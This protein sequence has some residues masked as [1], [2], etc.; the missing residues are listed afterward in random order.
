VVGDAAG[1]HEPQR[2]VDLGGDRLV[3]LPRRRGAHELAVPVV[4][5]VQ[6]GH[7]AAGQGAHQ[8]HRRAGVGVRA[9]HAARV[10]DAELRVAGQGVD[11]VSAVGPETEGVDVRRAGL[12]VLPGDAADLDHRRRRAVGEHDGHLQQRADVAAQVGLGVVGEGLRAVTALQQE[13]LAA[14]D[15]RE[16]VLQPVHL[17]GH[18]D[19]RDVLEHLADVGHRLGVRPRGLLQRGTRQRH[20]EAL[21]QGRGQR[22]QP[23]ERIHGQV[24]GPHGASAY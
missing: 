20:V 18:G 22:G 11:H 2:A 21:T 4:H 23:G 1:V 5:L 8:V 24:D 14:R 6:V 15:R 19:R 17:G 12:R 10:G 3:P 16:L 13:R 7:A 9:D